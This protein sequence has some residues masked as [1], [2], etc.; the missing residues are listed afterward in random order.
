MTIAEPRLAAVVAE[1]RA[2]LILMHSREPMSQMKGFSQYPEE[3][4]G[5]VVADVRSEWRKARA[6]AVEGGLDPADV[7]FDPGLGFNKNARQSLTLLGRL[8]EF[9]SEDVPIVV[10]ASRKSFIGAL[11][12]TPPERRVG[13]S[14]AACLIALRQGASVVRVHDVEATKQALRFT[15][16]A[17]ERSREGAGA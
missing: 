5:D 4:Y 6:R 12:N 1:H 3:G 2:T 17:Q 9:A 7:W 10:G 8:S 13:G 16:A 15:L 11:D 14:I